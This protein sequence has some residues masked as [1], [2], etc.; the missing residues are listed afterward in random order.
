MRARGPILTLL[1][2]V[3]LAGILLAVNL[4]RSAAGSSAAQSAAAPGAAPPA[5]PG[6]APPVAAPPAAPGSAPPAATES[7]PGR[8]K[9]TGYTDGN[10]AALAVAVRDNKVSAYLCD[11][12]AIEGWYQG[13]SS[14][15]TLEAKGRGTNELTGSL[16]GGTLTGTVSAGGRSW[17]YTAAPAAA[18][19]GLYRSKT[20]AGTTGW[21]KDSTGQVTGLTNR[22][23]VS[24]PAPPLDPA[25]AQSVEGGDRVVGQ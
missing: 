8:A 23:G 7:F 3:V 19:A 5:A 16:S 11:G 2:M 24:A 21:V 9:Y 22:G 4:S 17:T 13:S 10:H 18:P 12:K 14:G 15:G 25:T 20:A 6:S 1:V